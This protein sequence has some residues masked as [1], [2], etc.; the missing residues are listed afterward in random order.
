MEANIILLIYLFLGFLGLILFQISINYWLYRKKQKI[1]LKQN[2]FVESVY[3]TFFEKTEDPVL[4]LKNNDFIDLNNAALNYLGYQSKKEVYAKHPSEISP[5]FQSN[6]LHSQESADEMMR[7]GKER[8]HHRFEWEHINKIGKLLFVEVSITAV[9]IQDEQHFFVVWRDLEEKRNNDNELRL[10]IDKAEESDRLKSAF[11]ES[12]SHEIRTPMNA[13]IGFAQLLNYEQNSKNDIHEFVNYINKSGNSLLLIID[14]IIDVSSLKSGVM[15]IYESKVDL[16]KLFDDVFVS[17]KE[18][19]GT[20]DIVIEVSNSLKDNNLI[21]STD[22]ARLR[23]TLFQLLSNAVKFTEDGVVKFGCFKNNDMLEFFVH[24]TG[25]GILDEDKEV[26]FNVFRK[27][28][29]KG[30]KL[31]GGTG[32]GLSIAKA[33]VESMGG[34]IWINS[35]HGEGTQVHFSVPFKPIVKN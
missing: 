15:E 19:I 35:T 13:I 26:V 34:K 25:I 29:F 2:K 9:I 5:E 4:L 3:M 11:L 12:I 20:K 30:E 27:G 6:G 10:A 1:N 33:S 16:N 17:F 18:D 23:K 14:N 8:G 31:Y 32:L 7:I 24:D 28:N 22:G 21:I